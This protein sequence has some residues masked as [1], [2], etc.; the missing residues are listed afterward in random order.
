MIVDVDQSISGITSL[1]SS[2]KTYPAL[3]QQFTFVQGSF[4]LVLE[5]NYFSEFGISS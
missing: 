2:V 1:E 4:W 5:N 3:V